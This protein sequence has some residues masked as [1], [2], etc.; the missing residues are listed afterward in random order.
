MLRRKFLDSLLGFLSGLLVFPAKI[1]SA[2]DSYSAQIKLILG[3]VAK[4]I[5]FEKKYGQ[6]YISLVEFA[7]KANYGFFTNTEKRKTVLYIA[8]DT[9]KFTADNGFVVLNN[10][11]L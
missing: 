3:S 10:Q 7:Q 6:N 8:G 9:I 2:P 11:L 4:Y 1:F 5:A